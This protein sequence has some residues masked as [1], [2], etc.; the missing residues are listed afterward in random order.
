MTANLPYNHP[1][2]RF[3]FIVVAAVLTLGLRAA[4]DPSPFLAPLPEGVTLARIAEGRELY[5]GTGLCVAC[6]GP[7]GQGKIGPD[8]TDSV[9]VHG[10]GS[11]PELIELI[12]KGVSSDQSVSGTEMLPR[13]GSGIGDD[14]VRKVA[15]YVWS[16]S[17]KRKQP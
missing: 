11:F 6:H 16:L 4:Q 9:W 3:A 1:M 8:L 2:S 12:R 15:A 13:G 17:Q 14:E 7:S 5:L 10:R